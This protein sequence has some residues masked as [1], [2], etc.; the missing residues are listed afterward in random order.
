MP[1][2]EQNTQAWDQDY[3]WNEGGDEWSATWGGADMQWYG[4][5]LPRIQP[6]LPAD[7]VL[8]IAPGWGRWTRYLKDH[9][10][11]LVGVD[12]SPK[13]VETCKARFAGF[14][15]LAFHANDGRSLD[16]IED[17]SIDFAFSFDSLVHAESDVIGAYLR[18]LA[19]KLAPQGVGFLHHSNLG[20]YERHFR[21]VEERLWRWK[22]AL[23]KSRL[24]VT[25]RHWRAYSMT[26]EKFRALADEAG[27][28]CP[29]QEIV[30][31]GGS[32]KY[33]IDCFSVIARKGSEWD[34]PTRVFRN[35]GF[36]SVK[37]NL[38]EAARLY[39]RDTFPARPDSDASSS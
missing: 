39:G 32:R 30:N 31:W 8:E 17:E 29:C 1:T 33:L 13:C 7:H 38:A 27:L 2:I 20:E 10:R 6:F 22:R 24:M 11:A 23:G 9:G 4:T 3:S 19:K 16:V 34:R 36:M 5:I 15:N 26:A 25:D 12:L 28:A 21:F 37:K 18:E 14:P 35:Q